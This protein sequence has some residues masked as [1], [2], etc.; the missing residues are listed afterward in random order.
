MS[1]WSVVAIRAVNGA[2]NDSKRPAAFGN[3]L[4]TF[5]NM[6]APGRPRE[7]IAAH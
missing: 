5:D 1:G 4:R 7:E 3:H 6:P 2:A